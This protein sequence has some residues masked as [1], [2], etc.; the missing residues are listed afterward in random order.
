MSR[1]YSDCRPYGYAYCAQLYCGW[2]G[3]DLPEIDPEGNSKHPIAAWQLDELNTD[4]EQTCATCERT[5]NEW[6]PQ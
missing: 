6:Q 2:C 5:T 3:Y 1:H 4:T